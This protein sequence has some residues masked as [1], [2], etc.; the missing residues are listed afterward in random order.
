MGVTIE[1]SKD[2]KRTDVGDWPEFER[3]SLIDCRIFSVECSRVKSPQDGHIHDFYRIL[4]WTGCR[5]CRSPQ[6][7]RSS[8]CVSIAMVRRGDAGDSRRPGRLRRRSPD[9]SGARVSG[10]NRLPRLGCPF[11]GFGES[12]SGAVREPPLQF[13]GRTGRAGCAL[14]ATKVPNRRRWSWCRRTAAGAAA[15]R[16]HRPRAGGDDAVALRAPLPADAV[17]KRCRKALTRYRCHGNLRIGCAALTPL[18][19]VL[20][21][22]GFVVGIRVFRRQGDRVTGRKRLIQRFIQKFIHMLLVVSVAVRAAVF[23]GAGR[24]ARILP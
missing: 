22:T 20:V 2:N 17:G 24:T 12:E 5:S 19:V 18:F 3:Q 7:A 1:R 14:S 15:Q 10:G 8:W 21:A 11:A 13:R 6:I 4:P 16:Q 23:A 9:C